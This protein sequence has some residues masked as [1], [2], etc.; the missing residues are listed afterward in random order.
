MSDLR[1]NLGSGLNP[2]RGFVNVDALVD[3]PG[4]DVVA[5]ISRP[6]PFDDGSASVLYVSHLLE[7]FPTSV[8]PGLLRDWRRV[9]REGGELLIAVPD[10]DRIATILV[11]RRGW[12]TPPNNPWLGAIYGGQKDEYDFHKTGFT[13][14]WLTAL[15][16][17]AGFGTVRRVEHFVDIGVADSSRSPLPFGVNISLNLRATAGAS[18]PPAVLF[19]PTR[20][21]R[22][23]DRIDRALQ[24]GLATSTGLRARVMHRRRARLETTIGRTAS[25]TSR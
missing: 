6:L 7:H 8:V 14:V 13:D 12:F 19:T 22:A 25:T 3:L 9:L 16:S 10:L 21:E 23:L 24:Y 15:L 5:D 4:V 11:E 20:A 18:P 17:E 2:L 1:I